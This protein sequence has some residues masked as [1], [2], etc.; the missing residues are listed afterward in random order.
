MDDN[1]ERVQQ[2]ARDAA[3]GSREA[4]GELVKL[5]SARILAFCR[6]RSR[7]AADDLAQEVFVTAYRRFGSF[8]PERPFGPWLFTV[9]RNVAIDLSRRRTLPVAAGE[10]EAVDR[11]SP[12]ER[13]SAVDAERRVWQMARATLSVRQLEV[14]RLRAGAGLSVAETAAAAG[15]SHTAVKVILFRARKALIEAG[16]DLPLREGVSSTAPAVGRGC[17]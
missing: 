5:Y 1:L 11:R 13:A 3:E 12:A 8:N 9:A 17:L 15:L 6:S 4:F 7:E 14:L 2:L 10:H 16:A